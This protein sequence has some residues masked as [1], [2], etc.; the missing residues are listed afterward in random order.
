MYAFIDHGG[1]QYKV[2]VGD[3]LQVDLMGVD[4]GELVEFDRVLMV[5]GEEG[6]EPRIGA[7]QL[8]G[9]RVVAE[10]VGPGKGPKLTMLRY[11]SKKKNR[12][13]VGHRQHYTQV[14]IKEI[15]PE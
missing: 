12:R 6:R 5:A 11:W 9:A 15:H 4:D 8:P 2:Q 10:V 1:R 7:P 14:L 13:K 3:E